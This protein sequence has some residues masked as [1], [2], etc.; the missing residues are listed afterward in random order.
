MPVKPLFRCQFCDERP[1][2]ETQR[3]LECQLP[4]AY[5]GRYVDANPGRWLVWHGHGLLGPTRYACGHHR[6]ELTAYLRHH[7]GALGSQAWKMGP[8][9]RPLPAPGNATSARIS[10]MGGSGFAM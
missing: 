6:G 9:P 2:G 1:D 8:Y 5:Y 3:E 10:R 4:D 7:Y